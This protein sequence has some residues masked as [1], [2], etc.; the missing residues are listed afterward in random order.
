MNQNILR[1]GLFFPFC[2]LTLLFS[3][4]EAY[5]QACNDWLRT[6]TVGSFVTIG[7]LDISGNKLTVE[8]VFNRVSAF[9]NTVNFGKLVS[10]HT[11]ASN[12]NYSLMPT[13]CEITTNVSGYVATPFVCPPEFD[14]TYHVAMVYDG[15]TLKFYRDGYVLSQVTCT[16]NLINNNLLTTIGQLAGAA[17]PADMQHWGYINEV[18]IW[19][20]ARTQAE[21]KASMHTSLSDP[22]GQNGLVAY[23]TFNDLLNRQGNPVWNGTLNGGAAIGQ[24]NP[25]CTFNPLYCPALSEVVPDFVIPDTVCVNTPVNISNISMNATSNYWNFCVADA[26]STPEAVNL[27]NPGGSLSWPVFTDIIT[28]N[29]NYYMFVS[30]NWPGGLVRLDFGNSLLNNPT[31]VNLGTVGGVIPNTIEGIQVVKNEGRWYAIMVGGDMANGNI[32]SRVIKIDFGT[33]ITNTNP[34]GTNWGNIGNL[35]YPTDLHVFEE[36][37]IWYGFTVNAQNNT[38]TRFNFSNSFTNTPTAVNLGNLGGLSY[39]TGINAIKDNG[40][41]HVFITNDLV[42]SFLVRLDF[43]N[44]LLNTPTAVNLG[45]PGNVLV[46][47]RD[48]YIMKACDQITALAVNGDGYNDLVK[49]DFN[50]NITSTPTGVSLGNTGGMNFPHSISKLFRVGNDLYTFVTNVRNHSLTRIRFAGCTST[51]I[52]NSSLQNPPPI[53]YTTPGTYNISLTIDD[54]LPTQSSVCKQIVVK[55]CTIPVEPDFDIPDTVCV[56]TP[57]NITNATAG[58]TSHYWNFCVADINQTPIGTNLGNLGGQLSMP[59]FM[60]LAQDDNGDYYGF[61]INHI[62]GQLIRYKFGS[63]Y[64]NTPVI[65]NLGN[66]NDKIP[67]QAEGVQVIKSNGKWYIIIVGGGN[68]VSNSSPR[69]VTI[70]FGT[71]LGSTSQTANNWGNIGTLSQPIDLH[72]FNEADHWYG[73]T[74]NATHQ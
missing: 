34:V 7:D 52:P 28:E 71:S 46:K 8:A 22:A 21:L 39:P 65:E 9:D 3:N 43:G 72:V 5:S 30:N 55:D 57:V 31:V 26:N 1:R 48:I 4:S 25:N 62:P 33:S 67:N 73:F 68:N 24:T 36:N 66:Y 69:I 59:V 37:G 50:N 53:T 47:T 70:N 64:L 60:D 29:G 16:G 18:R 38:I 49:L 35:A 61:S 56:N 23:Y 74:V 58:A 2:F 40:N 15:A 45:N 14:K 54:G 41:W 63:S 20:A 51:N 19:K 44:S 12:L 32:P 17:Q 13:Q 27:G 42:N 6:S 11:D 10:K